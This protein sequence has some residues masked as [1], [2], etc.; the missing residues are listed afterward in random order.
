MQNAI[1]KIWA[2]FDNKTYF[3]FP[4]HPIFYTFIMCQTQNLILELSLCN[5]LRDEIN[6]KFS[7]IFK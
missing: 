2:H 5:S 6:V 1:N 4:S 3:I 7:Y